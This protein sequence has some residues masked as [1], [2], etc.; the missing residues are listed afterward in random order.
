MPIVRRFRHPSSCQA[1]IEAKAQPMELRHE[2]MTMPLRRLAGVS[3]VVAAFENVG[4]SVGVVMMAVASLS[5]TRYARAQAARSGES[6]DTDGDPVVPFGFHSNLTP[7]RSGRRGD[8]MVF[9]LAHA[10]FDQIDRWMTDRD[11][12]ND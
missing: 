3:S 2:L 6:Q 8:D 11:Q 7:S 1:P 5:A 12:Q 9:Q 10:D 4:V